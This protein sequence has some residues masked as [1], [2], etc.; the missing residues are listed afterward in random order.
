MFFQINIAKHL[1]PQVRQFARAM[2]CAFIV[3]TS[4]LFATMYVLELVT[5]QRHDALTTA[6]VEQ[7]HS[8]ISRLELSQSFPVVTA[9][10]LFVALSAAVCMMMP[11]QWNAL[12]VPNAWGPE[13]RLPQTQIHLEKLPWS[14]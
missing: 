6:A 10:I 13:I 8:V 9:A 12:R 1:A 4:M 3:P 7:V 14:C 11:G 5:A 2:S